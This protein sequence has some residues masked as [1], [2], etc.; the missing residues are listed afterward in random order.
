MEEEKK[1]YPQIEELLGEG[2]FAIEV[3]QHQEY[4][5]ETK[6][7]IEGSH[8]HGSTQFGNW[9]MYD[10]KIE[11]TWVSLFANDENKEFFE[12]GMVKVNI[13]PKRLKGM[14]EDLF[15]A[16]GK[17]LLKAFYNE[18]SEVDRARMEQ[19]EVIEV[20]NTSPADELID[21]DKIKF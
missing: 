1:K 4:D 11:D 3:K 7:F 13:V 2:E 16:T 8:R 5:K 10:T 6:E 15:D 12:S 18:M 19:E 21:A 9:Y 20:D 14:K 17:K